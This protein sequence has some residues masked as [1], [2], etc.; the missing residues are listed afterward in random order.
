MARYVEYSHTFISLNG[1][2]QPASACASAPSHMDPQDARETRTWTGRNRRAGS[3]ELV[4][5]SSIWCAKHSAHH[6]CNS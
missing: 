1:M 6:L 3:A 4:R 5:N 2:Q